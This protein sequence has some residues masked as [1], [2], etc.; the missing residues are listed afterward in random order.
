MSIITKK[1]GTLEYLTAEG[2]PVPHCFTTRY[3]GVSTGT[4]AS[5]N[6]AFGRG[7]SM[8]NV[9]KNLRILGNA[10]GFDPEKLVLTRQT[11][12]D[13]VRVVTEADCN[14]FCH[15]DYPECDALV[16]NTPGV[17]L[18]V[19][20]ADCT[21]LLLH[22]P[23]TGAVGAAHAGWRGTAQ[24][25]GA[26]TVEAM[27]KNFGCDVKNIRAA[28]GPNIAQCHFETD[29]DVPDAMRAAFGEGVE[30]FIEKR[31]EKYHLDLKQIN[32][33]I[34]RRAGVEHIEL[35]DACT[36]CQCGRFWSH[37]VTKGERGSQGAV[38]TCKEAAK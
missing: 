27:V 20:T 2:I 34:L 13:I 10:L 5:L 21:P 38:I 11:H 31:G 22:D 33:M 36:Y 29:V 4:Q 18:L 30:P 16:T 14:G 12:S 35:S 9:E 8:E 19:F 15:K 23:V 32:A 24:A 17:S 37:R 3:G 26:K 25:I 1:Q 7:D 6:L 28:I